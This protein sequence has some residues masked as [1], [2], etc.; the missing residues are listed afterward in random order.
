MQ[1]RQQTSQI[2]FLL[3]THDLELISLDKCSDDVAFK[4]I[5]SYCKSYVVWFRSFQGVFTKFS[6]FIT[7]TR[8][9]Y[10]VIGQL[11][12]AQK[13][14]RPPSVIYFA[15][16]KRILFQN[17][18]MTV[19]DAKILSLDCVYS[20][21]RRQSPLTISKDVYKIAKLMY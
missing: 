5:T 2:C 18:L 14:S 16:K 13:T 15:K 19:G 20:R 12:F 4:D 1:F 8:Y 6:Q 7:H 21:A 11:C 9:T 17:H 10:L 3:F